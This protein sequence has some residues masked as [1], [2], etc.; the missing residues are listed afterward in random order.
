VEPRAELRE[1]CTLENSILD[2][3][4]Y[5]IPLPHVDSGLSIECGVLNPEESVS[6]QIFLRGDKMGKHVFKF[7]FGYQGVVSRVVVN[8]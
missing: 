5:N 3:S 4:L 6:I 7:L 1:E 2:K 8:L